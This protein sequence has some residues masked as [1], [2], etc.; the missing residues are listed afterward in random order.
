MTLIATSHRIHRLLNARLRSQ[1]GVGKLSGPRLHLLMADE[2]RRRV[3]KGD[4]AEDLGM[5]ARTV[6]TL[7]DALERKTYD[8]D[9]TAVQAA[10]PCRD[11]MHVERL[12][13]LGPCQLDVVARAQLSGILRQ[14]LPFPAFGS[15]WVCY[16]QPAIALDPSRDQKL[17]LPRCSPE[18]FGAVPSIEQ[19]MR[20]GPCNRLK[21]ANDRLHQVN[22]AGEGH[23]F[24]FA[25]P[26]LSIQLRSQWAAP[27]QEHIQTLHHTMTGDPFPLRRRMMLPQPFHLL[28]FRLV[29]RRVI[30]DQIPCHDGLL[31]RA[32]M[33][34]LLLALSLE[35]YCHLRLHRLA[36]V[37]QPAF[38]H[39]FGFPG[40]FGEKAAQSCQAPSSA[41]L[42]QQAAQ[43]S[44]SFTL[45]QPQQYGHEVLV[46]GLREQ[47]LE[48]LGKVA[49]L[50]IQTYNGNWHWTP[51]WS[52]GLLFFSLIP[53][54]VL[55]C[56]SPFQK[57]KH[58]E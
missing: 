30:P 20:Q 6:T 15:A 14:A 57:C 50:F 1:P 36:K 11:D 35:L 26:L 45:H 25:D 32:S 37:P 55:S 7:I 40:R 44:P 5:T 56:H 51:P 3:R 13:S 23:A 18:A 16:R 38:C 49:H 22:L 9:L 27:P 54:G 47:F 19:D 21:G 28:A 43:G 4:V 33:L 17:P 48:P 53:H 52:Q 58:R 34:G 46:L 29:H 42:T 8:H 12:L 39:G 31:G 41:T 24:R 2:E 10:H